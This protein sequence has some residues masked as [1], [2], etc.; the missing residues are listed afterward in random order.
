MDLVLWPMKDPKAPYPAWEVA[1]RAY[2]SPELFPWWA[3]E[4]Q[5]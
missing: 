3:G 2:G 5:A 1:A 4:K